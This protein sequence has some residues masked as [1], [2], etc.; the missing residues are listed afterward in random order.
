MLFYKITTNTGHYYKDN[1]CEFVER[2]KFPFMGYTLRTDTWRLT[3]WATW[4]G[5][6][7]RPEWDKLAGTELYAHPAGSG[8]AGTMC[9]TMQNSCFDDSENVNVADANSQVVVELTAMLKRIVSSL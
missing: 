8:A 1:K 3:L 4:N 9:D 2:S 6:A 7:L 5:T